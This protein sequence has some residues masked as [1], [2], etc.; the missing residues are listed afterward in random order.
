MK[1]KSRYH[2][3]ARGRI[4]KNWAPVKTSPRVQEAVAIIKEILADGKEH[5]ISELRTAFEAAGSYTRYLYDALKILPEVR[6]T[7]RGRGGCTYSWKAPVPS[8]QAQRDANPQVARSTDVAKAKNDKESPKHAAIRDRV[9]EVLPGY[10]PV[11][12]IAQI[13]ND[14]SVPI[15]VRLECHRDVAKYTTPMVKA[16]EITTDDQ[17]IAL[18]FRWET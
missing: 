1:E 15:A 16:A 10:D 3:K 12:S 5:P 7:M 18:N 4:T 13:A 17:P 11:V 6:Q 8:P 9:E 14:D 2:N